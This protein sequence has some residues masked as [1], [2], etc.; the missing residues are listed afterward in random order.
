MNSTNYAQIGSHLLSTNQ[1]NKSIVLGS[2]KAMAKY[3][4][5]TGF[6]EG[7]Y[8]LTSGTSYYL[9]RF[10]RV[11]I[12]YTYDGNIMRAGVHNSQPCLC[13]IDGDTMGSVSSGNRAFLLDIIERMV[14]HGLLSPC[15]Q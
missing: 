4:P 2:D 9:E 12:S 13:V 8:T 6:I 11:P 10:P 7:A 1:V 3:N 15:V 14:F 5:F